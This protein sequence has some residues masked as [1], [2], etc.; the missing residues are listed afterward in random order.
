MGMWALRESKES[1]MAL[2][3]LAW[4]PGYELMLS[5]KMGQP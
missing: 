3:P 5:D 2:R 1:G 4:V